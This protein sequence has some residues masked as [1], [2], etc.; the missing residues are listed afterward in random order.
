MPRHISDKTLENNRQ[1]SRACF[2]YNSRFISCQAL[3]EKKS[4]KFP[5]PALVQ[6]IIGQGFINLFIKVNEVGLG[7]IWQRLG[8]GNDIQIKSGIF[9]GEGII[10]GPGKL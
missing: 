9:P 5:L 1:G 6:G 4:L 7:G 3:D 10:V 2:I 8:K